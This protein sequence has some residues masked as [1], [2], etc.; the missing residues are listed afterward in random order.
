MDGLFFKPFSRFLEKNL[1]KQRALE[2]HVSCQ[3]SVLELNMYNLY[4]LLSE[5]K[6]CVVVYTVLLTATRGMAAWL[7]F[8]ENDLQVYLKTGCKFALKPFKPQYPHTNS[9]N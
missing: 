9:P 1:R 3:T 4:K 7:I 5:A 8:H 6:S 2:R